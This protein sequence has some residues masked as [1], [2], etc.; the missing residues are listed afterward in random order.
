M[1]TL[2]SRV[3]LPKSK[4]RL[5]RCYGCGR[6]IAEA[7]EKFVVETIDLPLYTAMRRFHWKCWREYASW[8]AGQT[9]KLK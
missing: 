8:V 5:C 4:G 7:G 3:T 2:K 1:R 6:F 9:L